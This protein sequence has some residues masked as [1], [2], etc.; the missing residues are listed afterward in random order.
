MCFAA[1]LETSEN[2]RWLRL[3]PQAGVITLELSSS[4]LNQD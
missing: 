4:K 3:S 2:D 1:V